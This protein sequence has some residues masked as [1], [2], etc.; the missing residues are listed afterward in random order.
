M[1]TVSIKESLVS[2]LEVAAIDVGRVMVA[3]II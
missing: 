3:R 1:S 2:Q